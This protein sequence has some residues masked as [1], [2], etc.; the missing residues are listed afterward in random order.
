MPLEKWRLW[1]GR[2][3]LGPLVVLSGGY[4]FLL[5]CAL[6]SGEIHTVSKGYRVSSSVHTLSD[7]PVSF[8]MFFA[9]H[10]ALAGFIIF[11]T[12]IVARRVIS[13]TRPS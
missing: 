10:A 13:G 7:S 6:M 12:A 4:V 2:F 3:L 11:V 1:L 5:Y 9:L 8:F